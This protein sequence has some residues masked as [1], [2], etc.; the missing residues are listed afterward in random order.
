MKL[1]KTQRAQL[2]NILRELNWAQDYILDT[3]TFI[4]STKYVHT[5]KPLGNAYVIVNPEIT[6]QPRVIGLI[7]K[8]MGS[9][10]CGLYNAT[11]QL[12]DLL[13]Q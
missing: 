7:T 3:H 13:N 2:E 5:D 10:I 8:E 4:A 9:P 11:K 6:S 12:T 1:S